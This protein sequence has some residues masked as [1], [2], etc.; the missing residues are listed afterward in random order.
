MQK[1]FEEYI[2][3]N[4]HNDEELKKAWGD[5]SVSLGTAKLA[6]VEERR[7]SKVG[8]VRNPVHGRHS[9]SSTPE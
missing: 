9:I 2:T 3:E 4:Y 8:S 6:T 7:M 1:A 5:W